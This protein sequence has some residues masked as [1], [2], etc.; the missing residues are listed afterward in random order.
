MV[1]EDSCSL[2]SLLFPHV[3]RE[4][5]RILVMIGSN[6]YGCCQGLT[7]GPR[8]PTFLSWTPFFWEEQVEKMDWIYIPLGSPGSKRCY[9]ASGCGH[10]SALP[11]MPLSLQGHWRA[12]GF[13]TPGMKCTRVLLVLPEILVLASPTFVL[14]LLWIAVLSLKTKIILGSVACH[15][16]P[17]NLL[18]KR[19]GGKKWEKS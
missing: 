16:L 2:F 11:S 12:Q 3:G 19:C 6:S 8:N 1:Q 13:Q 17:S 15:I 10:A 9:Q 18:T 4:G 14:K 5:V 7:A